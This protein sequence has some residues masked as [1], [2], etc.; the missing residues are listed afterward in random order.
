MMQ[1]SPPSRRR[2]ATGALAA[3]LVAVVLAGSASAANEKTT[4]EVPGVRAFRRAMQ[5]G[6]YPSQGTYKGTGATGQLLGTADSAYAVSPRLTGCSVLV[7]TAIYKKFYNSSNQAG[8]DQFEAD[9]CSLPLT[10]REEMHLDLRSDAA[11]AAFISVSKV[12]ATGIWPFYNSSTEAFLRDYV[13]NGL[14]AQGILIPNLFKP[15]WVVRAVHAAVCLGAPVV[16]VNNIFFNNGD[17]LR[18]SS[19]AST[20][21]TYVQCTQLEDAG[22]TLTLQ[23]FPNFPSG[24]MPLSQVYKIT[25]QPPTNEFG[26]ADSATMKLRPTSFKGN[27]A[28]WCSVV[29]DKTNTVIPWPENGLGVDIYPAAPDS[30]NVSLS[31]SVPPE[32]WNNNKWTD[33]QFRFYS[34][35][36]GQ[37]DFSG[38]LATIF[39]GIYMSPPPSPPTPPPTPPPS[40]QPPTPPPRPPTPFPPTPPRPPSPPPSCRSAIIEPCFF[41]HLLSDPATACR[42]R[43]LVDT[44]VPPECAAFTN[45]C[46]TVCVTN[47]FQAAANTVSTT[48]SN[49]LAQAYKD[50]AALKKQLDDM[51]KKLD[52]LGKP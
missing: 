12:V 37:E 16:P 49:A 9:L 24:A 26:E 25:Y 45:T 15:Y 3:L 30:R 22:L 44:N 1:Q 23:A 7:R 36:G 20:S 21:S 52:A 10:S 27:V 48:T 6:G 5:A 46:Q 41:L 17:E 13:K 31:C 18:W 35:V 40:P 8:F 47:A 11:R 2:L 29:D 19:I 34:L 43:A 51:Q 50:M 28:Q 14:S 33:T 38:Y 39:H 42:L 32:M 4:R